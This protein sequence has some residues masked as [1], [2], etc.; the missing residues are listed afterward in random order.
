MR[1]HQD[2]SHGT[3]EDIDEALKKWTKTVT[4]VTA[5]HVPTKTHK[6][7]A[8]PRPSRNT[9]LTQ[10]QFR[11]LRERAERT[12]WTMNDY[13]WYTHLRQTL[14]DLR[15]TVAKQYW[16]KTLTDMTAQYKVPRR[17]WSKQKT[18]SGQTKGPN[19]YLIDDDG[20]KHHS[21]KDKERL[22]TTIWEQVFKDDED[23]DEEGNDDDGDNI[24]HDFMRI[25][26]HR[27]TPEHMANPTRL[28]GTSHLDCVISTEELRAIRS[29]KAT[30]PGS[31]GIGK[32]ILLH[33]PRAALRRLGHIY[34]AAVSAGYFPDGLKG[35]EMRLIPKA[36]KNPTQPGNYRPISLLEVHGKML[37]RVVGRRLQAHLEEEGLLSTA[38]YG[39]RRE[40]GTVHAITVATDWPST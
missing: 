16:G 18:L 12:G 31:S 8:G 30:A 22:F 28:T 15:R 25:N 35:A 29:S 11:A 23:E 10:F 32:T 13:R 19:S 3:L 7:T 26:S 14:H 27:T 34:S 39:F 21:D 6:M 1:D 4:N 9:V 2:V 17:F 36:G 40:R 24:V 5:R 20:L 38:Q 37:E 33:L